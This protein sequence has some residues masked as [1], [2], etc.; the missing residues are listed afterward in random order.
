MNAAGVVLLV[1]RW[2]HLQGGSDSSLRQVF[3]VNWNWSSLDSLIRL[4]HVELPMLAIWA[5][6]NNTSVWS[7]WYNNHSLSRSLSRT[8]VYCRVSCS[9]IPAVTKKD[10]PVAPRWSRP[11]GQ[12]S[13]L[14]QAGWLL[15]PWV[16]LS[17]WGVKRPTPAAF[18]LWPVLSSSFNTS[19]KN[20]KCTWNTT[21]KAY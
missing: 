5:Y 21:L 3:A 6:K 1:T 17:P 14:V 7:S 18:F 12:S 10:R 19:L 4:N 15:C 9:A 8:W 11:R 16:L 13:A 20:N 2:C